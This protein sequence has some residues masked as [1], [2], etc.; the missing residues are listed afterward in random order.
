[1]RQGLR[2]ELVGQC[3]AL[4][5]QRAGLTCAQHLA[6]RRRSG[7]GV[8]DASMVGLAALMATWTMICMQQARSRCSSAHSRLPS[9]SLH[10]VDYIKHFH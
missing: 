7:S 1:M 2:K 8:D 9:C 5:G 3:L 6:M 10:T 4:L